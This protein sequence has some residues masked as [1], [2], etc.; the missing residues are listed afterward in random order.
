MIVPDYYPDRYCQEISSSQLKR[1]HMLPKEECC[2][3]RSY[4]SGR[5][6]LDLPVCL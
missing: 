3:I 4:I 5:A 1:H 2:L 6:F